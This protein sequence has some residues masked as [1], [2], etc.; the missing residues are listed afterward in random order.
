[1]QT[2]QLVTFLAVVNGLVEIN[3]IAIINKFREIV[4]E[5]DMETTDWTITHIADC[6]WRAALLQVQAVTGQT[7]ADI[8]ANRR[9]VG[10]MAARHYVSFKA[11][12][13]SVKNVTVEIAALIANNPALNVYLTTLIA[14]R[15]TVVVAAL[16]SKWEQ[17][18]GAPLPEVSAC[19]RGSFS[20]VSSGPPKRKPSVSA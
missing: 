4:W 20:F 18:F 13:F 3:A 11:V 9:A 16:S 1:M 2:V 19:A 5:G 14:T 17:M 10:D 12:F 6:I 15:Q 8:P 7:V